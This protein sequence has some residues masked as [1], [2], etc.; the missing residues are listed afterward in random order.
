M[1]TMWDLKGVTKEGFV[2]F[3][4]RI[5]VC[6]SVANCLFVVMIYFFFRSYFSH[7]YVGQDYSIQKNV[8]RISLEQ[9]DSVSCTGPHWSGRLTHNP[10]AYIKL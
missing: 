1:K 5:N 6:I 9:V 10:K 3:S 4:H 2:F 7:A 8:G